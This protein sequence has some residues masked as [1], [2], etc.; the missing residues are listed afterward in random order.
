ME[1]SADRAGEKA[2]LG[3]YRDGLDRAAEDR[4]R[5]RSGVD[6]MNLAALDASAAVRRD[7]LA[8]GCLE[9]P[10]PVAV[11]EKLV[12]RELACPGPDGWTLVE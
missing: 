11:A 2:H 5:R 9:L 6:R 3:G 7:A 10:L 1:H 4:G 12:G 8:D